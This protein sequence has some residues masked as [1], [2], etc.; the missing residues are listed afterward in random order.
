MPS[1]YPFIFGS[2]YYRA[3]TP[4]PECWAQDFKRMRVLGFNM[5]KLWVQ[6]RW[7]HRRNDRFVFDDVDQLMDLAQANGLSVTINVVFDV[8]PTWL[9]EKYPDARQ[10]LNNGRVIKPYEVGHR[11]V[12]G[13]PGPCY[14]H[15]GCRHEKQKFFAAV[16]EHY[17]NHPALAMWDV[18]NEPELCFPQREAKM[19][20]LAC[21][22]PN[23]RREFIRWLECKYH[24][25]QA[26]NQVWGRCYED[27]QEVEPPRSGG[28]LVDFVDWREFHTDTMTG[29]AAWRIDLVKSADPGRTVYLHVVPNAWSGWSIVSCCSDDFD[30]AEKCDVFAATMNS[31]PLFTPQ[32]VSAARGKLCYNVESHINFG[33]TSLHPRILSL[34]DLL[35]D[36]IPQIGMGIKGFLFWQFRPEVLGIESPAWGLVGLDGGDRPITR[37]VETFWKTLQPYSASLLRCTPAPAQVGI[38]KS[39]KN[40]IFQFAIH[41]N[42]THLSENMD[43]YI[44]T[45]WAHNI[46]YRIINEKMLEQGALDG[47]RLLIMPSCYY[48]TEAEARA[49]DAW[50]RQGGVLLAE[51]HLAGYN[52]DTGRHSRVV[53]GCGLAEAW[54]IREVDSTSSFHLKMEQ[55]EAFRSAVSDDV[56]KAMAGAGTSGGQFF[57]IQLPTGTVAWGS[58]RYARLQGIDLQPEGYFE[59]AF[60]CLA[61]KPLGEGFIFYSGTELG[62]A[63]NMELDG[64]SASKNGNGLTEI[65]MKTTKR[66]GIYPVLNTHTTRPGVVQIGMLHEDGKPRFVTIHNPTDSDQTLVLDWHGKLK[67]IF[68]QVEWVLDG[69]TPMIVPAGLTDILTVE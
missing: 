12:G 21:Y 24:S 51:A 60:P 9:F 36:F 32:V 54:G 46:P 14:N 48:V 31:G 38:W 42:T 67:G 17:K 63:A 19:D 66:A 11:Q 10:V 33:S 34:S 50:V 1:S 6:W 45:L 59:P 37:A 68:S 52:A 62:R 57:P 43:G 65:L 56:R 4:E 40:E 39:R 13:H 61:S 49:L 47:I 55:S 26:L 28:T 53:P 69:T 44:R 7:S 25:L 29:E 18:W 16:I 22:C 3:P 35:A 58:D 15:P 41:Q 20:T 64:K 27:W 5:V 8:S 30:L 23:C 2:Q